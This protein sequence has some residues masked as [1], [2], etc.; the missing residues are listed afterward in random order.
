M[1]FF[2]IQKLAVCAVMQWVLID[3]VWVL[4]FAALAFAD[5]GWAQV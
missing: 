5:Y 1:A 4:R 2:L 3:T